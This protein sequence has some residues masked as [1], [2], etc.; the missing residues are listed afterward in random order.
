MNRPPRLPEPLRSARFRWFF[1]G[2]TL[3]F[4]GSSMVSVALAF[5]VL[6]ISGS[7]A[8]LGTVL[9]ARS[10]PLATF[11]LVGGVVS[12]RFS[13]SAVLVVSNTLSGVTQCAAAFLLVSGNAE[14]WTLAVIEAVNGT[15]VAFTF[16][17]MS[18]IV[19]MVVE[20]RILQQS[21][22]L[23]GFSRNGMFIIGPSVAAL[24]VV[25]V[26]SG[27][28]IAG[29]GVSYLVSAYCMGRLRLPSSVRLRATS[30]LHDLRVGWSAFTERTWLWVVV[31]AFGLLNMIHAGVIFTL[32]PVIAK[33]T[34]G[35]AGWG[36][37]LSAQ[38]VG[39]LLMSLVLMK[40]ALRFPLRA[41]MIGMLSLAVPM[42]L[43]GLAPVLIPLVA[44]SFVA[45]AGTEVFGI[46][47]QTAMHEHVPNDVLSR[48]SA[49]DA[50]GSI[51]A[52]PVGQLVAGPLA[53]VFGPR[54]VAVVGGALYA[55]IAS[56]T[57]LSSSVR[58][59]E[60]QVDPVCT[61]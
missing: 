44:L 56:A 36:A 60:H 19:P 38:S 14:I 43:L 53:A 27:W 45:G 9:A 26:G 41:G 18:S 35:E 8:A 15:V 48:V 17:A 1:A 5:A 25:T 31:V 30:M 59:L 3:S 22:A 21:N 58:G 2:R 24:L 39:F 55:L 34:F 37:V 20:R 57:L 33:R 16:P 47:W 23:L 40:V 49:Y 52:V 51:V 29:D 12:D 11:M 46:G 54:E 32:G 28:A 6:D 4:L 42:L 7:P 10:I 61:G 50:L 13:R